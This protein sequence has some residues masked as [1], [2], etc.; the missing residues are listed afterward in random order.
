MEHYKFNPITRTLVMSAGFAR[1]ISDIR[2]DEYNLYKQIL[3]DVPGLKVERKT[4]EKPTSYKD[5]KTGKKTTYYPTKGLTI[6]KME[7]F[8]NALPEGKK[9]LDEYNKLKAVADI[10]LSPYAAIRRWFE[11]QFPEYRENPLFYVHNSVE[12]IDFAP[13]LEAA[14]QSKEAV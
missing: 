8:M 14:K 3:A 6:K 5:K 12:V 10:C 11:A 2:S 4:N 9:Y 13:I 7:K 1:A